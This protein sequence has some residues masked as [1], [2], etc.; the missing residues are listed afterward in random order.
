M[1]L[2]NLTMPNSISGRI[3]L[4]LHLILLC[5][6]MWALLSGQ[7]LNALAVTV[8]M[9]VTLLPALLGRRFHVYIPP[10]FEAL[11]LVFIF[12]S[13]F[14]GE[15]HGYYTRF[16]W[17]DAL[18]HSASGFILGILG[19]LLVHVLN[20]KEDLELHMKPNFVALFAFLFAIGIGTLWEIFEFSMDSLLGL[21]M[22]KSGLIDTMW[23]LI[24]DAAGAFIIALLGYGYLK[25]AGNSSFLEQWIRHFIKN[26]PGL[27]RRF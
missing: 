20:E 8:I 14:L 4:V 21:N 25:T 27:F 13:L 26:N 7:W 1:N 17:W 5:G 9:V 16:W 22:Q 19:F 3:R 12:A 24:V 10:E 2:S 18:L 6:L 11:T 23:D 15:Y